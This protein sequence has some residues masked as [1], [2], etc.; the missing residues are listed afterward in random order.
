MTLPRLPQFGTAQA[1]V[2]AQAQ[3]GRTFK[4]DVRAVQ[5]KC[6]DRDPALRLRFAPPFPAS[7]VEL[8][9]QG[10][11]DIQDR[12]LWD[13]SRDVTVEGHPMNWVS[14][15][16]YMARFIGHGPTYKGGARTDIVSPATFD[17]ESGGANCPIRRLLDAAKADADW[18]YLTEDV[19]D[20]SGK[21]LQSACL[22]RPSTFYAMNVMIPE[23]TRGVEA[24]D[25]SK[26]HLGLLPMTAGESL[27]GRQG[28]GGIVNMRPADTTSITPGWGEYMWG[29]ITNPQ[30]GIMWDMTRGENF[31]YG[32]DR[33]L[34][35][36]GGNILAPLS[37]E[38]L[39]ERYNLYNPSEWLEPVTEESCITQLARVFQGRNH[40]GA[41]EWE[42]LAKVFEGYEN[43]PKPPARLEVTVSIPP[44]DGIAAPP[45][46]AGAPPPPPAAPAAPPV[47]PP[48]VGA[49]PPPA[50]PPVPETAPPSAEAPP[51]QSVLPPMPPAVPGQ[52][53]ALPP[54]PP[55]PA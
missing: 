43:C 12:T 17:L 51:V 21:R 19:T 26:I 46:P 41:H 14:C 30:S 52:A 39:T 45:I 31:R 37:P 28:V 5:L 24:R 8:N 27:L 33:A 13:Y 42:L 49:P 6:T 55:P 29:D 40:R 32:I 1:A 9:S 18:R 44:V 20:A 15:Y 48:G 38:Q 54:P 2:K 10:H 16:V 7:A 34:S 47:P 22:T 50:A 36:D 23:G 4:D 11:W 53:G 25:K 35:I 3:G